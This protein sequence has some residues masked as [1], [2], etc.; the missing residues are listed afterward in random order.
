MN[1]PSQGPE[2]A[3]AGSG[4]AAPGE[5]R[6]QIPARPRLTM[7]EVV[8]KTG[9]VV[10]G[11]WFD[12]KAGAKGAPKTKSTG[13][14]IRFPEGHRRVGEVSPA[15]EQEVMQLASV[16]H[17]D[18][19]AGREPGQGGQ[20][21][22]ERAEK[23]AE[24][25]G[26]TIAAGFR[27]F[28]DLSTG[29]Y[30]RVDDPQRSDVLRSVGDITEALGA[31]ATW[32]SLNPQAAA[33][34]IWRHVHRRFAAGAQLAVEPSRNEKRSKSNR[35]RK[36]G[37]KAVATDGA[38]W[39][40]RTVQVF[41]AAAEWLRT[42][43]HI[44]K[45]ACLRP[46]RWQKAFGT[47]WRK[48][49]G[50]DLDEETEGPRHTPEEAGRLLEALFDDLVDP[51]LRI[52]ILFGGDS[53]RAGQ[54]RRS[55]RSDL[56]LGPCGEFGLGRLRVRGRG[57][58]RGSFVDLDTTVRDAIDR[59]M[60]IGYLRECEAA[61]QAGR[62]TDYALM[63][64]GR[65]VG[66][67][68]PVRA[69]KRYLQPVAKRS[70]LDWFHSLED[71]ANVTHVDGRGWYGLRRLWSDL[72]PDHVKSARGREVMGGWARGSKVADQVY[73]TKEDE[74]A[75]REAARGRS[76]IR[77]ALRGGSM[78]EVSELRAAALQALGAT[79]DPAILRDVLRLLGPEDPT[80]S[81]V[82]GSGSEA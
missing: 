77:E 39:A 54:V 74:E 50:R 21:E 29:Q 12:P 8:G 56:D 17:A 59:E 52:N 27:Q 19:V 5:W 24:Q 53:L 44:P 25:A 6:Y 9:V 37:S 7:I 46:S 51:R 70:M 33:Q 4:P 15:R 66:G 75:I 22:T 30:P 11:R 47:D 65:F 26:V 23:A 40:K 76:A 43:D 67:C 35:H 48:L 42:R 61:Y 79:T 10:W 69:N 13:K 71:V 28:M 57:K 62:I 2:Q 55:I 20:T 45:D 68:T 1:T 60:S 63:P 36:G 32:A 49:T 72:T 80:S 16:W 41:F 73:R 3:Q 31:D 18:L 78:S 64:Q 81:D 14:S 58:K 38:T 82:A 34:A